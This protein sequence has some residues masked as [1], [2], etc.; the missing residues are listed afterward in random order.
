[1]HLEFDLLPRARLEIYLTDIWSS[2]A[3]VQY[4]II[5]LN[6]ASWWMD[7]DLVSG[8]Q[9]VAQTRRSPQV[10]VCVT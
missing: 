6:A 5:T 2:T 9:I 10:S 4:V 1:M 8:T 3:T 7:G